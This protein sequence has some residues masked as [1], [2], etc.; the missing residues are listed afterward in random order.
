MVKETFLSD[1]CKVRRGTG[2]VLVKMQGDGHTE[3]LLAEL[4][5]Y[6]VTVQTEQ[7]YL[8]NYPINI[9]TPLHKNTCKQ[10]CIETSIGGKKLEIKC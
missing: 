4:N 10:M 3:T 9:K 6:K 5:R 8:R 7:C 1:Q 2:S